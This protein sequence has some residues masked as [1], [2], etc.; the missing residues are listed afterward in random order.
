MDLTPYVAV[1]RR[2]CVVAPTAGDD[3]TRTPAGRLTATLDVAARPVPPS[4]PSKATRETT[5]ELAPGPD[6]V[7]MRGVDLDF[8]VAAV[9]DGGRRQVAP[10]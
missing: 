8:V 4:A 6:D 5:R 10:T 2:G 1:L 3:D 9:P 7:R